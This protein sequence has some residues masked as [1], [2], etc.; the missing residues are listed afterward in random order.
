MNEEDTDDDWQITAFDGEEYGIS[1]FDYDIEEEYDS[2]ALDAE[3]DSITAFEPVGSLKKDSLVNNSE[4]DSEYGW[5]DEV[6]NIYAS[7]GTEDVPIDPYVMSLLRRLRGIG[8]RCRW[9][10]FTES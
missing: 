1:P 3:I 4:I 7:E 9:D 5:R 2:A 8:G 6:L 10:W